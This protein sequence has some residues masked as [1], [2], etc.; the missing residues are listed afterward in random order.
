M[1]DRYLNLRLRLFVPH[2][3]RLRRDDRLFADDRVFN[4]IRLD[5]SISEFIGR[6]KNRI[7]E[8]HCLQLAQQ[9]RVGLLEEPGSELMQQ[10]AY[11]F[12][13]VDK[14]LPV[15]CSTVDVMHLRLLQ[16]SLQRAR[17]FRQ[18][19]EPHSRRTAGQRMGKRNRGVTDRLIDFHRPF[20]HF[21]DQP[22]RPLIG[23]VQ[24]NVVERNTNAQ[25]INNPNLF[26]F[27]SARSR[28]LGRKLFGSLGGLK[29]NS[30]LGQLR[31]S[32]YGGRVGGDG[33]QRRRRRRN[34][35]RRS[36]DVEPRD[37]RVSEVL[38]ELGCRPFKD[39]CRSYLA[40]SQG[41]IGLNRMGRR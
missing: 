40:G 18:G 27:I 16:C 25:S 6:W 37:L 32:R 38:I 41:L 39:I 12:R 13:R 3:F 2:I 14:Q 5:I 1:R 28:K 7:V 20:S 30:R 29:L 31:Q 15:I 10:A 19:A 35:R 17:D 33:H 26:F 24:I 9:A 4:E 22:A 36:L 34:R 8:L 21:S 23:L 11:V